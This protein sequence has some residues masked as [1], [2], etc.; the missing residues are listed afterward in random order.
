MLHLQGSLGRSLELILMGG[1]LGWESW[2]GYPWPH[3][4][5][6]RFQSQLYIHWEALFNDEQLRIELLRTRSTY[7]TLLFNA[8]LPQFS[9]MAV[10]MRFSTSNGIEVPLPHNFTNT[11]CNTPFNFC[12]FIM[13][14]MVTFL[15]FMKSHHHNTIHWLVYHIPSHLQWLD[16][17]NEVS[18]LVCM[19]VY[20][21]LFSFFLLVFLF[22]VSFCTC[23]M[24]A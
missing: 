20:K 6:P 13:C 12:H 2:H 24:L 7:S 10:P 4:V 8:P 16:S 15:V 1:G 22:F 5:T 19:S 18:V 17:D 14:E 23:P 21:S 9:Q 11:W 3:L